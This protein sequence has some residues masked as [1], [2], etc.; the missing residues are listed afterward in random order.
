[1]RAKSTPSS[2]PKPGGQAAQGWTW[3]LEVTVG[4]KDKA[5]DA[6]GW[7]SPVGAV[8]SDWVITREIGEL[9]DSWR[10]EKGEGFGSDGP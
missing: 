2:P 3:M 10:R 8:Y 5:G 1:M 9:S 4:N 7:C 6:Q